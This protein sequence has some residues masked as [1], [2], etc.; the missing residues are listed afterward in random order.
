GKQTLLDFK[1]R[2]IFKA[3]RGQHGKGN[4]KT[5][6]GGAD[7]I[8]GFPPGTMVLDDKTGELLVDLKEGEYTIV[9]GGRGGRGNAQFATS[10]NTA[11]IYCEEGRKG[12]SRELRLELKVIADVG[13][14]GLPNAGKSSFLAKVTRANP[15]IASYPFST[16]N[17]NLGIV[18]TSLGKR[19]VIADI[20]G[21]IEG[22]HNGKGLGTDFLRH[23]ARTKLLLF[24]ID[25][26]REYPAEDYYTLINEIKLYDDA[27][28]SKQRII[29]F[30]KIDI[31]RDK[32]EQKPRVT[33]HINHF[34]ISAATGEGIEPLIKKIWEILAQLGENEGGPE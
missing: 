28:I 23:I 31:A 16:L 30:N 10:R 32:F 12:E 14:V 20:P 5:G 29:V 19:F 13:L 8:I 24:I 9:R 34:Y 27:L 6:A 33:D 17:P 4:W 15:K 18:D 22:A 25:L 26:S 3:Q 7:L 11:P 2:R 21:L 1:Y